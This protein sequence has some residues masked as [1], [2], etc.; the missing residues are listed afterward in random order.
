MNF[1][2]FLGGSY[3]TAAVTADQERTVNLFFENMQSEGATT[4]AALY[5]TPGVSE[6]STGT[7][8]PGRGHFAMNGR[9]FAVIGTTFYEINSS[10]TLTSR[11]TVAL[12]SNPATISSNGEG[13]DELFVTSGSNGYVYNLTANTLTQIAALNGKATMGDMIDGYFLALDSATATM[14]ISDLLDGT[15]WNPTQFA[16]RTSAPDPW[17]SMKVVGKYI[18]LLGEATSEPWYNTG[19]APFPFA[20]YPGVLLQYGIAAPFSRA[21][22]G[23]DLIWLGQAV[24]GRSMVLKATGFT[25]EVISTYPVQTQIDGYVG[26]ANALADSYSDGGHSFYV[27]TFAQQGVTWVWDA[28]TGMWCERGTWI[29]ANNKFTAWRPRWHAYAFSQHRMLDG[30]TTSVYQMS[31]SFNSDVDGLE[32]RRLRRAPAI[33]NEN[34]R[35]YY[36]S[37]EL[38]LEPGLGTS[39]Q[40]E[41]PQVMLRMSD[42]GGKTWGAEQMRSAGK[43]GQYSVRVEWNRLGA[44]RRRVFEV[45]FTDPIPWKITNAYLRLGQQ[46][47]PQNASMQA[48]R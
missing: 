23:L 28:E 24:E 36:A 30:E 8:G 25:P 42:D 15:T 19:Q 32:I 4:R 47:V 7:S 48:T 22:L 6:L 20:P 13:G 11:G 10:G 34:K 46:S 17:I 18:Y 44:A 35:I 26:V 41:D 27:L 9:E 1:Q 2:G 43:T 21:V 16:Q 37:F 29:P 33:M 39:G 38:D 14:Y 40:G 5:P 12:D 3:E 45:S 31:S